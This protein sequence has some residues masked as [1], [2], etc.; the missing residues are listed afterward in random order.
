EWGNFT[1]GEATGRVCSPIEVEGGNHL[2]EGTWAL[3]KALNTVT[4]VSARGQGNGFVTERARAVLG[5]YD[6]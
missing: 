2:P 1:A 4:A 6:D 3:E 5:Y